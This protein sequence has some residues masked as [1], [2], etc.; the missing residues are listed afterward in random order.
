M[1]TNEN[2]LSFRTVESTHC[3]PVN[4]PCYVIEYGK[5]SADLIE[6]IC[7]YPVE[8]KLANPSDRMSLKCTIYI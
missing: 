2:D 6:Y 4:R 8:K 5:F 7:K 1:H 3:I